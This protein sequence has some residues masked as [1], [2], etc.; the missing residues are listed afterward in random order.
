M[1]YGTKE[2]QKWNRVGRPQVSN[3]DCQ[4]CY[5]REGSPIEEVCNSIWRACIANLTRARRGEAGRP[6][7]A[8]SAMTAAMSLR[9]P[10]FE[11]WQRY[12]H[13]AGQ[14]EK[15]KRHR[16][17]LCEYSYD[18]EMSQPLLPAKSEPLSAPGLKGG[19]WRWRLTVVA[20]RSHW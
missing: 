4:P 3:I 10:R 17:D 7:G 8:D 12:V 2:G 16:G 18:P 9:T 13:E 19:W 14:G 11:I 5:R 6:G 20:W 1:W 15:R